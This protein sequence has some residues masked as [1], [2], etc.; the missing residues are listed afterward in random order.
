M[1]RL[2]V[3]Y[4]RESVEMKKWLVVLSVFVLAMVLAACGNGK[5]DPAPATETDGVKEGEATDGKDA[6]EVSDKELSFASVVLMNSEGKSVGTAELTE[7][8]DGV[9]VKVNAT[10][11]PEGPHGFHFH[12]A[13]KCEAP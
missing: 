4:K 13:G 11:L 12:E 8:D 2:L 6:E 1:V 3:L 7:E 10:D 5:D 9:R